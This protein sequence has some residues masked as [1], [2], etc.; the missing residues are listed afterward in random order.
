MA[1]QCKLVVTEAVTHALIHTRSQFENC[2]VGTLVTCTVDV[3]D[4]LSCEWQDCEM[5]HAYSELI[6]L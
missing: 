6:H 3:C 1:Q 2:L 5:I 4:L